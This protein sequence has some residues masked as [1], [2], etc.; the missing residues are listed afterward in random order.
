MRALYDRARPGVDK[1]IL[2]ILGGRDADHDELAQLALIQL[3]ESMERF[4][5]ECSLDTWISRVAAYTVYG[6]LP[7]RRTQ[8]R[9]FSRAPVGDVHD[10]FA[11]GPE[12]RAAKRSTLARVRQHLDA[13]DPDKAWTLVLH[14]VC[15][16]DL[17]EIALITT[18]SVTAAQTR[19]FRGRRELQA[20]IEADPELAD[21]LRERG[22]GA[23][24]R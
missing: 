3:V 22:R 14:D 24:E 6:Q 4:R 1:T 9:I 5:G 10:P 12:E 17:R 18:A 7:K 11:D 21:V 15:G 8:R 23:D 2:R 13:L 19:L 20:R 16:Y